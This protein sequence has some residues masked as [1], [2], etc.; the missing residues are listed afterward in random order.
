M[1]ALGLPPMKAP[2][3]EAPRFRGL[4]F[5]ITVLYLGTFAPLSTWETSEDPPLRRESM[6]GDICHCPG[7]KGDDVAR[8]VEK[9]SGRWDLNC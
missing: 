8:I 6:L 4:R 1:Q 3:P 2:P 5:Q 7:K 9:Q